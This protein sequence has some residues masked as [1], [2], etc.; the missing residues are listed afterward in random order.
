[1]TEYRRL[2]RENGIE[3]DERYLWGP[4]RSWNRRFCAT[5]TRLLY[6]LAA[7][8]GLVLRADSRGYSG[9][10]RYRGYFSN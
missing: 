8:P 2:L 5:A 1:L 4:D 10:H 7:N 9:C 3:F 6:S